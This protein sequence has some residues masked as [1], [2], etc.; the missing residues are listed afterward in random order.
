MC[1]CISFWY[2]PKSKLLNFS[3]TKGC[4]VTISEFS[5]VNLPTKRNKTIDKIALSDRKGS[6]ALEKMKF[7]AGIK[8]SSPCWAIIIVPLSFNRTVILK[9]SFG[10]EPL[11]LVKMH[12]L[13]P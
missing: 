8:V 10:D 11:G 5:P 13:I 6:L 1:C 12:I 3:D 2:Q 9:F 7:S 4:I